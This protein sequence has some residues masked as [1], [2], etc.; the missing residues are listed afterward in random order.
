MID[1]AEAPAEFQADF[2]DIP[3][4]ESEA[5]KKSVKDKIKDLFNGAPAEAAV[6]APA[7]KR[8]SKKKQELQANFVDQVTPLL[9]L[10]IV[11]LADASINDPYKPIAPSHQEA[12]A[13]LLPLMRIVSRQLDVT[14]RLDETTIDLLAAAMALGMYGERAY[15]TY[16]HIRSE[17]A[18]HG[19]TV[20][21]SGGPRRP[22]TDPLAGHVA[23]APA[24]ADRE[25]PAKP[26]RGRAGAPNRQSNRRATGEHAGGA[27]DPISDLLHQDYVGRERLGIV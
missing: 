18:P 3:A 12:S 21:S 26:H 19:K 15:R 14:G 25:S 4:P 22:D 9:A 17:H 27:A 16:T 10:L 1:M 11:A 23:G 5:P 7:P 2:A 6:T 20:D 13:F 24:P 8:T